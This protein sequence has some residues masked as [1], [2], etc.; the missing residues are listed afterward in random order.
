MLATLSADKLFL[1]Y[2]LNILVYTLTLILLFTTLAL[3]SAREARTMNLL[4]RFGA[5]TFFKLSLLVS[6]LSLSGLPPF[7]GFFAKFFLFL[8]LSLKSNLAF[9]LVFL[10]FNLFALYFYLQSTRHIAQG[11]L[12]KTFKTVLSTAQVRTRLT[13]YWVFT[14]WALTSGFLFLEY[15]VLYLCNLFA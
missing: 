6:F 4:S 7:L 9:I 13:S 2:A 12:K 3:G 10:G 15:G 1:T 11:A 14:A 8:S 5:T